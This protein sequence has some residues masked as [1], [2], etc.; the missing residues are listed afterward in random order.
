MEA[1]A[2]SGDCL[3]FCKSRAVMLEL[4]VSIMLIVVCTLMLHIGSIY[5]AKTHY[6]AFDNTNDNIF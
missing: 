1:R 3:D 6:I 2:G 4:L 5:R